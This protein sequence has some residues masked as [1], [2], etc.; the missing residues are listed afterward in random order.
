MFIKFFDFQY[1]VF[2]VTVKEMSKMFLYLFGM[3]IVEV[4]PSR[5][6][7][8]DEGILQSS[9]VERFFVT[10]SRSSYAIFLKCQGRVCCCW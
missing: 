7:C 8:G 2:L 3:V 9:M 1:I 6:S 4:P 10:L 5:Q